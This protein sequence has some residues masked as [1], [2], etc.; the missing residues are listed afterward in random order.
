MEFDCEKKQGGAIKVFNLDDEFLAV[1]KILIFGDNCDYGKGV[2]VKIPDMS[3]I[4]G[5][6]VATH[7]ISA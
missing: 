1:R 4:Q 5:G 2:K 6:P 3:A 7:L